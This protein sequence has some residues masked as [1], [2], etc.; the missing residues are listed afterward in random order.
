[1]L[2]L[3]GVKNAPDQVIAIPDSLEN[4]FQKP[5]IHSVIVLFRFCHII[6]TPGTVV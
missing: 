4:L 6:I 2:K 3:T 1:M 5:L